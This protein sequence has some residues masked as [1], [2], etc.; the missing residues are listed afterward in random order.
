VNPD[1]NAQWQYKPDGSSQSD[2]GNSLPTSSNQAAQAPAVQPG[3]SWT[4][5]EYIDHTR[6]TGWYMLLLIITAGLATAIYFLTKDF[7]ATGTVV[8]LGF[9]VGSFAARR[10]RQVAYEISSSGLK[11]GAK[12]YAY[13]LFKSFSVMREG[14]ITSVNLLPGKR[15]MPPVSA[16]FDPKDE[17]Q[18]INTLGQYLPY[19]ER[20][21]ELID[22]LSRRLRF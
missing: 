17:Q 1:D 11:I 18:V 2:A 19:E 22:R 15:F 20:K 21:L 3:L 5:L 16:Y 12:Q 6:G 9:I 10:P 4:A 13:Q 14:P 8:V 7:F